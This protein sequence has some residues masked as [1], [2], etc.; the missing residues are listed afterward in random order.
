VLLLAIDQVLSAKLIER[1]QAYEAVEG[2]EMIAFVK[3]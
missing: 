2:V 1:M 3:D